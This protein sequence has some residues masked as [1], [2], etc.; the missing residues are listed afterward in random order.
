ML[1]AASDAGPSN[2]FWDWR[3]T[4]RGIVSVLAEAGAPRLD[5]TSVVA[6]MA[7]VSGVSPSRWLSVVLQLAVGLTAHMKLR[8]TGVGGLLL[9]SALALLVT[10][11]TG[12]QAFVNYYVV[13]A[14]L[15]ALAAMFL[16]AGTSDDESS[17][18]AV[19]AY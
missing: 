14:V 3:A 18:P 12:W 9:A 8:G 1:F 17:S 19:V 2:T 16:A 5:A 13:V 7:V 10:F 4:I 11:L 6:L 15:L